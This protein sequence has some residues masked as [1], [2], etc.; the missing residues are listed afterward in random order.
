MA[1]LWDIWNEGSDQ[2]IRS[3][4]IVTVPSEGAFSK[5]GNRMPAILINKDDQKAWL[6]FEEYQAA[7]RLLKPAD[8][9]LFKIYPIT[10]N[11]TKPEF[12]SSE[13]HTE[14]SGLPSLF[15]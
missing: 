12:N 7:L 9:H 13:L 2:E 10:T 8:E 11:I 14:I 5:L 4:T 6:E 15:D 1:G 3:F